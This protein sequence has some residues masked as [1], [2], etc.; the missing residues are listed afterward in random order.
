MKCKEEGCNNPRWSR[1]SKMCNIHHT[2][3]KSSA[4]K[5]TKSINQVSKKQA[6]SNRA[7]TLAKLRIVNDWIME[8]GYVYCSSCGTQQ[9]AIDMSHL[10]PISDN[11]QL[12]CNE[13]NILPQCRE[14]CHLAQE[15]GSKE[16][17]KFI[18][19]DEIMNRIKDMDVSYWNRLKAKHE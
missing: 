8:H 12:E 18:N 9:G 16:M 4:I 10:I 5:H 3:P 2:K 11:K 19:Y 6:Q 13:Q 15:I 17:K 1:K 14:V 7:V